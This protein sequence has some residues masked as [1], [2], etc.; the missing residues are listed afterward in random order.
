MSEQRAK[1]LFILLISSLRRL[2]QALKNEWT[3][4]HVVAAE[5]FNA[6]KKKKKWGAQGHCAIIRYGGHW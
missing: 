1:L 2:L 5:R 3:E 6:P 4:V